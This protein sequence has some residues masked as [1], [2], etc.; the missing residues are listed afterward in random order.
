MKTKPSAWVPSGTSR[1]RR[2]R[3][4]KFLYIADGE[5]GRV[6][7]LDRESLESAD[8]LDKGGR[9]PG[10]FDGVHS[11]AT[12]SRGNIHTAGTYRGQRVQ[13]FLY[14]GLARAGHQERPGSD[15]A[16]ERHKVRIPKCA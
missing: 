12:D 7:I 6:H 3:S 4:R 2:I 9:Q 10:E 8:K 15:V 1:S 13:R 5:N 14:N 11:V 16:Q